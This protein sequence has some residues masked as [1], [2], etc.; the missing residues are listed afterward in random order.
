[1]FQY[2][3]AALTLAFFGIAMPVSATAPPHQVATVVIHG[4]SPSGSVT[5]GVF[6]SDKDGGYMADI[7]ETLR[8][9]T[10]DAFPMAP[11]QLAYT[12][13]YGDQYPSYYTQRDIADLESIEVREGT[14]VPVYA[15][16]VAKY[17]KE[18]MRRSGASQVNLLSVALVDLSGAILLK[19]MWRRWRVP[20]R[21]LDGF[22]SMEW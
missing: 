16:I 18:V 1:M 20:A 11:N 10:G 7:A 12:T 3:L 9:P 22:A 15:A 6:G 13:Y 21:S 8:L 4:F 14:G 5:S 2:S 17:A 19:K